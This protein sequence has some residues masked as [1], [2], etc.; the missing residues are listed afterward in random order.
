MKEIEKLKKVIKNLEFS[1]EKVARELGIS[2]KT[3]SRWLKGENEPSDLAKY[4]I[5]KF[6]KKYAYKSFTS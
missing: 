4:Q 2:S 1:Q 6:I 3:I 5:E